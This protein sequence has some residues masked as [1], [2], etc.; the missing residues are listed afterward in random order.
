MVAGNQARGAPTVGAVLGRAAAIVRADPRIVGVTLVGGLLAAV[1][2]LG[3]LLT[4][5]ANG[6]A[7]ALA[8]RRLSEDT[9][10]SLDAYRLFALVAGA[11][12][13]GVL[14]LL[15]FLLF[16]LPGLYLALR[17]SLYAPAVMADERGPLE[18]LSASWSRT[19]H[20]HFTVAGFHLA[21]F[22][23]LFLLAVAVVLAMSSGQPAE[24]VRT[25][26][27]RLATGAVSAPLSAL[28]ASGVAVMY[29]G[30]GG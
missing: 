4:T 17:F 3:T 19:A 16:V 20:H 21:V 5:V 10:R 15:G 23:P 2:L 6:V 9:P 18:G 14:V 26:T 1:P 13:A 29:E 28:A 25:P 8:S 7:V 27:V 11:V 24:T 12:V 22:V 30:F